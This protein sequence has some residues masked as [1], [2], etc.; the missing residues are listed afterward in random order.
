MIKVVPSSHRWGPGSCIGCG[1]GTDTAVVLRGEA[2]W[3]LEFLG[4][5]GLSQDEAVAMLASGHPR[6]REEARHGLVPGEVLKHGYRVCQHCAAKAHMT[7]APA[8]GPVPSYSLLLEEMA[9]EGEPE[10]D[11][12]VPLT[13]GGQPVSRSR[14]R[15]R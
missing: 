11:G 15:R 1:Q 10:P 9:E 14:L 5:M 2:D 7:V 13:G 6:W 8:N 4:V 12:E 3:H